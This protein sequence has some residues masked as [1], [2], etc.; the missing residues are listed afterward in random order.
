MV[1]IFS[2]ATISGNDFVGRAVSTCQIWSHCVINGPDIEPPIQDCAYYTFQP[3][4]LLSIK[5]V[6]K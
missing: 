6:T 1:T 3:L 2:I 4:M 5:E